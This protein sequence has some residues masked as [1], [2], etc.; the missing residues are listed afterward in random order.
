[1]EGA[2]TDQIEKNCRTCVEMIKKYCTS[3]IKNII[4]ASAINVRRVKTGAKQT[5][6]A[7]NAKED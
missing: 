3:D 5:V 1:M 4:D 2:D 6:S 7:L